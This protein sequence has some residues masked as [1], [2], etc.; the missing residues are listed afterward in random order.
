MDDKRIHILLGIVRSGLQEASLGD[1][2]DAGEAQLVPE[3]EGS[4]VVYFV[5]SCYTMLSLLC[6][7]DDA[8]T[9]TMANPSHSLLYT[10]LNT[11][12]R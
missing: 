5:S 2:T 1:N 8:Q 4:D 10:R 11:L 9:D 12:P 7:C 3:A 6:Y